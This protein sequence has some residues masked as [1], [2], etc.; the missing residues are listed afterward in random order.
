[1][2][3]IINKAWKAKEFRT[4]VLYTKDFSPG[5]LCHKRNTAL[6]ETDPSF[7]DACHILISVNSNP[8][9][10]RFKSKYTKL[11]TGYEASMHS[12]TLLSSLLLKSTILILMCKSK[13]IILCLCLHTCILFIIHLTQTFHLTMAR[14]TNINI[15]GNYL[16]L[17]LIFNI[18]SFHVN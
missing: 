10:L 14:T 6:D 18:S 8:L 16:K 3:A 1:M 15:K 17:D 13:L 9:K 12:S 2:V 11:K 4:E 5:T 7:K